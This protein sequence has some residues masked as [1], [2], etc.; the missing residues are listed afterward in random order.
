[1]THDIISLIIRKT[2]PKF[3]QEST[4]AVLKTQLH[5][6]SYLTLPNLIIKLS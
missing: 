4:V 3:S 6:Y 2:I 1:M 5:H